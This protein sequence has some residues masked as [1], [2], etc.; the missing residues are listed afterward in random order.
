M[1]LAKGRRRVAGTMNQTEAAFE[2]MFIQ[3]KPHGFEEITLKLAADCRY[4]PD[5]WVLDED[6]VLAF[7]EVKGHWRDDAKVKIR[8]AA[9]KFPQFRFRAWT[10]R[11]RV[12]AREIFGPEDAPA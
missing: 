8:M 4:T 2:Q 6:D 10:Y 3:R 5:F 9:D 7:E 1:R 11:N 12:W